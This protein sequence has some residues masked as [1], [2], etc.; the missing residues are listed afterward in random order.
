MGARET[1]DEEIVKLAY[2]MALGPHKF[3][4]LFQLLDQ[5]LDER[6]SGDVILDDIIEPAFKTL[7]P[8][9]ENA[10]SL[11]ESQGRRKDTANSA[12]K[13]IDADNHLAILLRQ[14]GRVY[15]ANSAAKDILQIKENCFLDE[16]FFEHGH[17]KSLM[18]TLRDLDEFEINKTIQIFG[19]ICPETDDIFKVALTKLLCSEGEVVGHISVINISWNPVTAQR[20]QAMFKLT[21]VESEITRAIVTGMSLA[22]LAKQR[23]RSPNTVR[24]QCKKLLQKLNL[25]SQTELACL[26]SGFSGYSLSDDEALQ[27]TEVSD[28]SWARQHILIRPEGRVLDYEILGPTHA[29][30]V[31]FLPGL[32]GGMTVTPK[33]EEA[34]KNLNVRLIMAW[35]PG[36]ANSTE[37]GPPTAQAFADYA[38]DIEALLDHLDVQQCPV[39]S[40]ITASSFAYGLTHHIP[41]RI[42][43]LVAVNGIVP[44]IEGPHLKLLNRIERLR[45]LSMRKAPAISRMI[46]I[47]G[48]AKIDS[49]YD[50]EWIRTHL[51]D[52]QFDIQTTKEPAI[53]R[54]FRTNFAATTRQGYDSFSH[55]LSMAILDWR[56]FIENCAVPATFLIGE[57]N[58]GFNEAV[59]RA[60]HKQ[61]PCFD[62][63]VIPRTGHLLFYQR[64]DI[65]FKHALET[66]AES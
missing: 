9:F 19:I 15:H 27:D 53:R 39:I 60:Y 49:G 4:D 34:A 54:D 22:N 1:K 8:H 48:L 12:I 14:D 62:I 20:F 40:H 28:A 10:L 44:V 52:N 2:A 56:S 59:I 11:M 63:E 35:R 42:S 29:N 3:K 18:K 6:I 23:K 37:D 21:P 55:E 33:I 17:H 38:K 47:A 65:I 61:T 7:I 64:P 24:L 58:V 30:P 41:K 50:E 32:I 51:D 13:V 31:L 5:R 45:L 57:C 66:P 43:R 36:M 26:Y 46:L 25:R 16:S